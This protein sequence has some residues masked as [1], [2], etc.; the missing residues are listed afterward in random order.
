LSSPAPA[1]NPYRPDLDDL[2][3]W[4]EDMVKSLK[5]VELVAAVILLVTR[6]R[7]INSELTKQVA[8]LKR[9][10]PRSETLDRV[11]RQ[12]SFLFSAMSAANAPVTA[13]TPSQEPQPVPPPKRRWRR[14]GRQPLP[15]HLERVVE[16]NPVPAEMRIC[17]KCGS[18]MKT[19]G[20]SSCETLEVI[21]ARVIVKQRRDETIACPHDDSIVSAPVPGQIIERGVLGP[22]LVTEALADKYIEH[23]PIE[24]QA[25]R[26]VRAGV[27]LSPQTVGRTGTAA[28]DLLQPV[29]KRS[30]AETR[31]PGR[32]GTD[33]TASRSLEAEVEAGGR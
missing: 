4:L 16:E 9:R 11:Q 18:E 8:N 23:L 7:D 10:R 27:E 33:A 6:M 15:A 19:V 24:R 2:R 5:L 13:E 30:E 17:P 1:Q 25:V 22:T 14:T 12:L 20:H 3:A 32:W 26:Y 31:E 21:P 29:A 28:I